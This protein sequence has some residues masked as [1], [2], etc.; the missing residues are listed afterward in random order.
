MIKCRLCGQDTT[1]ADS[2]NGHPECWNEYD[3]RSNNSLCVK[4][5][6]DAFLDEAHCRTCTDMSSYKDYPGGST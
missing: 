5:G 1:D 6:R 3:R 4:C 2:F